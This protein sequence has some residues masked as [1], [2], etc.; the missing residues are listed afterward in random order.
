MVAQ[1]TSRKALQAQGFFHVEI[2]GKKDSKG[3]RLPKLGRK[4]QSL[5]VHKG[6]T[7]TRYKRH[8]ITKHIGKTHD[9]SYTTLALRGSHAMFP[10]SFKRPEPRAELYRTRLMDTPTQPLAP[11][12]PPSFYAKVTS[13][14][15]LALKPDKMPNKPLCA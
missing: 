11:S 15:H 12:L 7:A 3:E 2:L 14:Y 13:S 4:A 9:A 1:V 5:G 8:E 10:N 6:K